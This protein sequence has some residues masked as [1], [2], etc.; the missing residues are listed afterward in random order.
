MPGIGESSPGSW[1]LPGHLVHFASRLREAGIPVGTSEL[2]DALH[3]VEEIGL[4]RRELFKAALAATLVKGRRHREAFDRLFAEHFAP[5]EV[6]ARRFRQEAQRRETRI[7]HIEE[8]SRSL[9][10]QGE[11]LNLS[12]EEMVLYSS[13]PADGKN[14]LLQFVRSTEEGKNV[15]SR[16][17]PLLETVVKGHLSYW[18]QRLDREKADRMT[19]EENGPGGP[20]GGAAGGAAG[21]GPGSSLRELDMR[22]ISAADLPEAEALVSRLARNLAR[23]LFRRQARR[24]NRGPLDLRRTLRDN[25]RYGGSLFRLRFRRKSRSRPRLLLIGDV[26]ASMHRYSSFVLQFLYG[27]QAVVHNLESFIFADRLEHLTPSLEG[28]GYLR[29]VLDRVVGESGVWGGGTNLASALEEL[30]ERYPDLLG[31]RTTVIVVSDTRTQALD[32][33]LLELRRLQRKVRAIIW[34]NPLPLERWDLY[35]SVRECAA[36]SEMWPCRTIAQLEQ[37]A[38]GLLLRAPARL[39]TGALAEGGMYDDH[40]YRPGRKR[41]H[42]E[43]HPGRAPGPAPVPGTPG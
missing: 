14:R 3:A 18:R 34:L 40:D 20:G 30:H 22:A 31:A 26:S 10:F 13:L 7:S 39:D 28:R 41:R 21:S 9:L 2:L 16:H 38:A 29:R 5:P 37:V 17:K 33:A 25:L 35:R 12:E 42:R 4:D 27:L 1:G 24:S 19:R 15:E 8:A 23:N 32:L 11:R 36:L 43:D 6:R